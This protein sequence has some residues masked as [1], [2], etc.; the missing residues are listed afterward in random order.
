MVANLRYASLLILALAACGA[1]PPGPS[2][3]VPSASRAALASKASAWAERDRSAVLFPKSI[4]RLQIVVTPGW[5][6][7]E[8]YAWLISNGTDVVRVFRARSNEIGDIVDTAI[9]TVYPTVGTPLDQLSIGILGSY[10]KP[11]PP[12]PDPGGFPEAYVQ[13]VMHTAWGIDREQVKVGG[14]QVGP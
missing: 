2:V 11:P 12:P 7:G 5:A 6:E 13:E 4:G 9:K 10:H 1:R 3:A 8:H 14:G